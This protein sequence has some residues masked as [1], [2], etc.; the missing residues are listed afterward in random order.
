MTRLRNS[1]V[2]ATH[3]ELKVATRRQKCGKRVRARFNFGAFHLRTIS[4]ALGKLKLPISFVDYRCDTNNI[5]LPQEE[6]ATAVNI[7]SSFTR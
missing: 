5:C 6:A 7:Q 4:V 2:I 1:S 3:M